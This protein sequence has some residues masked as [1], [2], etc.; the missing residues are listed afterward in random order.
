MR[1]SSAGR[2]IGWNA[3]GNRVETRCLFKIFSY[4]QE[5]MQKLAIFHMEK[6]K[7]FNSAKVCEV[8]LYMA[9]KWSVVR[10]ITLL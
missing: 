10:P 4:L 9:Q 5:F 6:L 8:G 7:L 3:L 2:A 1:C